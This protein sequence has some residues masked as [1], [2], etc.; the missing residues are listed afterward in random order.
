MTGSRTAAEP[1]P[2]VVARL[3]R[4]LRQTVAELAKFGV[5]GGVNFLVDIGVFN[6]CSSV[7]GLGP[8]TS[9]TISV[10]VAATLAFIGNRYWTWRHRP[11]SSLAREYFLY[12]VMNAV[13]LLIALLCLGFSHYILGN[14]WPVFRTDLAN[15]L[16]G[17]IIGTGLGTL[18]R[19][20]SYRRWVFLPPT[21]PPVDPA[22]GLPEPADGPDPDQG[23][24]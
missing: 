19:F 2:G 23:R 4:R 5:V 18:F 3:Y 12:F 8:L 11:R 14:V 16:S 22:T 7:F 6:L 17:N 24:R 21:D 13:G 20:W 15:N 9:K 10:T 1:G